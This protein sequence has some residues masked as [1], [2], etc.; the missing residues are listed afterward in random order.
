M[1]HAHQNGHVLEQQTARVVWGG[2]DVFKCAGWKETR[3]ARCR[4]PHLQSTLRHARMLVANANRQQ[5]GDSDA[6]RGAAKLFWGTELQQCLKLVQQ[7]HLLRPQRDAH[8]HDAQ[9]MVMPM[10]NSQG[11]LQRKNGPWTSLLVVPWAT[12]MQLPGWQ[13]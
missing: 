6:H 10:Q 1:R 13:Q 11:L 2:A 7:Q 3:H 12:W 8:D 9:T 4:L 5:G